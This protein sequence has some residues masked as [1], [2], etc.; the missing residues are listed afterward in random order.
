MHRLSATLVK[1]PSARDAGKDVAVGSNILTVF[2]EDTRTGVGLVFCIGQVRQ[3]SAAMRSGRKLQHWLSVADDDASALMFCSPWAAVDAD[4]GR[5]LFSEEPAEYYGLKQMEHE[6]QDCGDDNADLPSENLLK[7]KFS[8]APLL[9]KHVE[10][11]WRKR[12]LVDAKTV[13]SFISD[14]LSK[15]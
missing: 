9:L 11:D 7:S 6:L 1:V 14:L 10:V 2:Q 3:I 12:E 15:E 4:S 8:V 13:V 5:L